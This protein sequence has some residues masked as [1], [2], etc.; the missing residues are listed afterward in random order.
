MSL[1]GITARAN[2]TD[3]ALRYRANAEPPS[4]PRQCGFCGSRDNVEVGH[5]NGH[6][7]D[8]EPENLIW[9]CRSCNVHASNTLRNAGLGRPTNQ[10]N[11]SKSGGA[12][13]VGEWIQAV[14]TIVPHKGE[15][16]AGYNYGLVSDMKVGDAVAMIRA[17]P[18]HKREEFAA[19]LKRRR[20]RYD[21]AVPF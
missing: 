6:E 19:L 15:Q 1:R 3:R 2:V 8:G 14:G 9:T 17:T 5:V 10:Y 12:S 4:G 16:Y 21:D 11:P 18:Q 13:N 20:G 7:E